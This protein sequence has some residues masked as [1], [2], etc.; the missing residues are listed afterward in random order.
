MKTDEPKVLCQ[1]PSPGRAGT[2]IPRWKYD[3]VR[4]AILQVVPATPAGVPFARLTDLVADRLDPE[5]C[6]RLG[7]VKWHT[8][9]VKLH[10]EVL[11]EIERVSGVTPQHLRRAGATT[12][13]GH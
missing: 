4:A 8:V 2:R 5:L 3:A 12:T 9:T 11:G 7:S 13:A 6:R 1:T 10:L